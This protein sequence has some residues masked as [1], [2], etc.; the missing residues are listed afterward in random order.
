MHDRV[1]A[2]HGAAK[3]LAITHVPDEEAEAGVVRGDV[4][5][6][7]HHG[8]LQLITG[9]D[10]EALEVIALKKGPDE[11]LTERAGAARDQY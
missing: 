5:L 11:S 1:D 7:R 6:L 4:V 3:T 2:L 10:D 8:L 9:V